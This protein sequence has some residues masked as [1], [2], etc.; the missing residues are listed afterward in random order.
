MH[1]PPNHRPVGHASHRDG[2]AV[3]ESG[4][5]FPHALLAATS[6]HLAATIARLLGENGS[7]R[8]AQSRVTYHVPPSFAHI[9]LQRAI[10]QAGAVAVPLA[11][12]HPAPELEY[13]IRDAESELLIADGPGIAVCREIAERLNIRFAT[14]KELLDQAQ[15]IKEAKPQPAP[16]P[17][18]PALIIYTSGTTGKPKGVVSSHANIAAQ[19]RALVSAWEWTDTDR[20][21]LVLPLHHVHGVINVVGCAMWAGACV[22][23]QPSFDADAA[24]DA[25]VERRLTLFMA[26]PTIYRRMIQAFDAASP[27]RQR[28][29]S[30]GARSLRLMVSGSAALP[31]QTLERWREITGHTLLERYGMTETG[32]IL[33]NPLRGD[34]RPGFVGTA[35]PGV[36]VRLVDASGLL[37][38]DGEAGE[39]E[40]RG[41]NVFKEYWRRPDATR[42]AFRDG[43][44]RTGDTAILEQGAYRLLGRSSVDILKSGGYKVSALEIEETLRTHPSIAECAVVGVPD[45]DFGDCVSA[46]V[47]LRAGATLTLEDLRSWAKERLAP[48]KIPRALRV[49]SALPR[50]AMGKVVKKEVT[51]MFA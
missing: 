36:E 9:A 16:K 26:V 23:I 18:D 42:D 12:T 3:V 51:R 39:L 14:I 28:A 2:S 29:M 34:R 30:D 5:D 8:N 41:A 47:E 19:V 27:D 49:V 31:V 37:V 10:W 7:A 4:Q 13:V 22:E 50:N 43:W 1:A 21:L 20:I 17:E 25:I 24:W 48:Y 45:A 32:M 40:C 44:F 38:R 15:V 35:L 6:S 33:S 11:L 46:A